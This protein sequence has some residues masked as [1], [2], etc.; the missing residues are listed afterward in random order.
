MLQYVAKTQTEEGAHFWDNWRKE[1]QDRKSSGRTVADTD[2][3]VLETFP[4]NSD[5]HVAFGAR[6]VHQALQK[7]IRQI[8]VVFEECKLPPWRLLKY[9][10]LLVNLVHDLALH[11]H[12]YA[13][14]ILY[15]LGTSHE[16]ESLDVILLA[17]LRKFNFIIQFVHRTP[18]GEVFYRPHPSYYSQC[19]VRDITVN[20]DTFR[21]SDLGVVIKS[22]E[23]LL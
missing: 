19:D 18:R 22:A 21:P 23:A 13:E 20:F 6:G 15:V 16:F 7:K 14:C 1:D 12:S 11:F 17:Q 3:E 5:D 2:A 4:P 10:H 8:V 9:R